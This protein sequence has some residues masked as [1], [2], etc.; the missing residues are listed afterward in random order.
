[1]TGPIPKLHLPLPAPPLRT[2]LVVDDDA[3]QRK[4]LSI[5]L[6]E[7]GYLVQT[8]ADAAEG[9]ARATNQPPDIIVSDV[10]MGEVD[11]F[12]F[13]RALRQLPALTDVPVIL[14]SSL[15]GCEADCALARD[16]GAYAL[17]GRTPSFTAVLETIERAARSTNTPKRHR[18]G[19]ETLERHLQRSATQLARVVGQA[20]DA[21][22]RY[23]GLVESTTDVVTVLD[24]NGVILEAN[25]RWHDI[26]GYGPDEM[27]GRHFR[28]FGPESAA[29]TN[30]ETFRR[31]VE[32]RGA[33]AEG[34]AIRHRDGR[35]LFMDVT[36]TVIEIA[37]RSLVIA[38]G[39]DV[40]ERIEAHRRLAAEE[41]RYRSLIENIP[42]VVW[43]ATEDGAIVY[44]NGNCTRVLGYTSDDARGQTSANQISLAVHPED[45]ARV[46]LAWT[47]FLAGGPAFDVEY[48]RQRPDGTWTWLRNRAVG[49]RTVDGVTYIDGLF[50]DINE[51]KQLE[52]QIRRA[53]KL[54]AVGQL[55]GGVAHDFNNLL[56][57]ILS[58]SQFLADEMGPDDPR[59]ADVDQI[60]HAGDRAAGLTRQLL[61][62]SRRQVLEPSNVKLAEVVTGVQ[63][64]LGRLLGEDIELTVISAAKSTMAR[65]DVGQ[66]EQVIMNLVV[67]ARDAMPTGGRLT[68]STDAID[69]DVA[70]GARLGC[71]AGAYV[72]LSVTDTGCG[73]DAVTR[74]R[75][76]EPFFTTKEEGRGTGLGLS[77]CYGIVTQSGGAIAVQS[78]VGKGSVFTVYLPR[79]DEVSTHAEA[80]VAAAGAKGETIV[81]VEDDDLVRSTIVRMLEGLGYQVLSA[82]DGEEAIELAREHRDRIKLVLSDVIMPRSS[83]FDVVAKIQGIVPGVRALCVSG[84]CDHAVLRRGLQDGMD[85]LPKPFSRESLARKLREMLDAA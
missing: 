14:I 21:E 47:A 36:S 58:Y 73:M 34:V 78:E 71:A 24:E 74:T 18:P 49:K 77:T 84:Y 44:V 4:L 75:I 79:I 40:T 17:V 10:V 31:A 82:H 43:T 51:Q 53:Q 37:G 55:V 72:T 1:M 29:R 63:K 5:Q 16:V 28:D 38:I 70:A 65:V 35:V 54:E 60:R 41:L 8:A 30:E 12:A 80:V 76:F 22:E 19:K 67:N 39:Q 13:C 50:T 64:M 56:A 46:W 61:A 85:F 48:R 45:R 33:R 59:R 68:I 83:G 62:F 26:L 81:V 2:V 42:D 3:L 66:L 6:A 11:G 27:I 15:F 7:A 32:T 69:V 52:E 23:R 25:N 9:I 20:H 57:I